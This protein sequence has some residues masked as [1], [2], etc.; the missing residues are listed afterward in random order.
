MF[1][2]FF[3][4]TFLLYIILLALSEWKNIG[5]LAVV[6]SW[7]KLCEVMADW[8]NQPT[9]SQM[10]RSLRKRFSFFL[11]NF[12]KSIF[13]SVIRAFALWFVFWNLFNFVIN[14]ADKCSQERDHA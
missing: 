9:K 5:L 1:S 3:Q 11:R 8:L 10:S 7:N 12:D 13:D 2:Y 4:A 6:I 14:L